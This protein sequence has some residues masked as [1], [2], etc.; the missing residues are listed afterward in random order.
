MGGSP[1]QGGLLGRRGSPWQEGGL[2]G[3]GVSLVGGAPWWGVSLAGGVPCDL[4]HHAFDVTC[5]LP[6]HQMRPTNSTAAYIVLVQGMLGYHP[7]PV[8]RITDTCK[9]V[10]FPQLRLWAVNMLSESIHGNWLST[11]YTEL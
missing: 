7:P 11:I 2:L 4:S 10:T 1:W 3:R 8:N 6:P 9:N 5:M